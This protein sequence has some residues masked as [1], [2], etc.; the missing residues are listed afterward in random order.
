V[1]SGMFTAEKLD[2]KSKCQSQLICNPAKLQII[3][4][5]FVI[6]CANWICAQK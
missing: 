1:A 5:G 3:L 6:L 2:G 4:D